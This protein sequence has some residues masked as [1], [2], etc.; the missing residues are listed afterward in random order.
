MS[1]QKTSKYY[2]SK[3]NF[4]KEANEYLEFIYKNGNEDYHNE[5][6]DIL[7]WVTNEMKKDIAKE[8]KIEERKDNLV[9]FK[10]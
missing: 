8:K 9:M 6:L 10:R 3:E 5:A 1:N 2:I 7:D 4:F